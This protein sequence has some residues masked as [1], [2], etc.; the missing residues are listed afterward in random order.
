MC[1]QLP[2]GINYEEGA[3]IEPLAVAVHACRQGNVSM[4]HHVAVLGAGPIG[5]LIAQV[6][7][8]CGARVAV[9]EILPDRLQFAREMGADL[10]LNPAEGGVKNAILAAW[11]HEPDVVL[12]AS[13]AREGHQLALDLVAPGGTVVFVGWSREPEIPLN[14]HLIGSKELTVRG[15]FRYRNVF[16]EAIA[17]AHSGKVRLKALIT[18]RFVLSQSGEA[19]GFAR[20]KQAGTIK[21]LIEPDSK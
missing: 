3:L 18:H 21:I 6:A 15:Q 14:V 7:Q 12:E 4:G 8:A 20:K 13:G 1:H 2:E 17:L 16:P 10:A 11:G 9:C 5:L 19:L